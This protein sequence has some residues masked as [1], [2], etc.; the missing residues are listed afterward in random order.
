MK[1][2][3][4]VFGCIPLLTI[5]KTEY[6][7]RFLL[8]NNIPLLKIKT[9]GRDKASDVVDPYSNE[10][11]RYNYEHCAKVGKKLYCGGKTILTKRFLL[12]LLIKN[13]I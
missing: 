7:Q 3:I 13:T 10:W 2:K 5:K 12:V 4:Y 11:T 6:E 9:Q 8:F 1:Q